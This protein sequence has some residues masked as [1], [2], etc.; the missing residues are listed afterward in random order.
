[1]TIYRPF[2]VGAGGGEE[3][4]EAAGG[5]VDG[6]GRATGLVVLSSSLCLCCCGWVFNSS[7]DLR[8]VTAMLIFEASSQYAA[9][10]RL[11]VCS[12]QTGLSAM[13]GV[14][15]SALVLIILLLNYLLRMWPPS[16][17]EKQ[18]RALVVSGQKFGNLVLN[19][20]SLRR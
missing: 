16:L 9:R 18:G 14:L 12:Q 2:T 8:F 13:P 4:V 6:A 17:I 11:M 20:A 3:P 19:G 1:M 10:N 7:A 15:L 5:T